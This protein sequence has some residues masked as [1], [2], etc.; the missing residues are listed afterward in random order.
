MPGIGDPRFERAVIAMCA[1]DESGSLGI[2]VGEVIIGLSFHGLLEQLEIDRGVAPDAPLHLGGP[3]E[4]QRGFLLH[5]P[6]WS[7]DDTL[8]VGGRW[9]LSGS[10]DVL[11]AIADGSGPAQ[12]LAALGY[13]GWGPEQ[14]DEELARHGW[15]ATRGGD[16]LL[17]ACRAG[18]RW[19]RA[20][21]GAGI[22]ARL[23]SPQP[24]RA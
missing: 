1:H 16:D 20:F 17:F 6:D 4:P 12:W 15:F 14:L 5:T 8:E 18:E 22:D 11:R 7:G 23:L 21:S 10:L 3:V 24:G 13:A 9:R 2:G 19:Q